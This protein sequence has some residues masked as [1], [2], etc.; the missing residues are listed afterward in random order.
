MK[1]KKVEKLM[2]IDTPF[3]MKLLPFEISPARLPCLLLP[4]EA[5]KKVL[6]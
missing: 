6:A 5:M 1:N 4:M 3:M 2:K